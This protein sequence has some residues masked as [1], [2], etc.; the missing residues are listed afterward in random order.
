[1]E[2]YQIEGRTN[3]YFYHK[4]CQEELWPSYLIFVHLEYHFFVTFLLVVLVAAGELLIGL[5]KYLL[6][7]LVL[8][9]GQHFEEKLA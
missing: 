9:D 5:M 1:M 3:H 8:V 7:A 6:V 2:Q 4:I